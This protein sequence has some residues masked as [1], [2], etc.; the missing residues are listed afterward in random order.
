[1][2]SMSSKVQLAAQTSDALYGSQ[3]RRADAVEAP[4]PANRKDAGPSSQADMRL[5]L[6]RYPAPG[7]PDWHLRALPLSG[8]A[9]LGKAL[10]YLADPAPPEPSEPSSSRTGSN[11]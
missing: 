7:G 3:T 6:E 5:T 9:A 10:G 2:D 1:M 11:G 8:A 4:A